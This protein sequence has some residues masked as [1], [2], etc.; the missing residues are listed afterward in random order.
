[1]ALAPLVASHAV[2]AANEWHG[3]FIDVGVRWKGNH[4]VTATDELHSHFIEVALDGLLLAGV[5]ATL[6]LTHFLDGIIQGIVVLL[7]AVI[8]TAGDLLPKT[9]CGLG[10][11]RAPKLV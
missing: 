11:D 10:V 5:G 3:H 4:A 8:R 9:L 1:M 7:T 6:F 2:T